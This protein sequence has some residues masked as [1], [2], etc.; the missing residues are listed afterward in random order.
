MNRYKETKEARKT[1]F[2]ARIEL[3]VVEARELD[4]N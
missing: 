3:G 1:R 4:S 2:D